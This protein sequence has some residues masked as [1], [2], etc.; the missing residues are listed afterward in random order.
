VIRAALEKTDGDP[1]A[2]KAL[3]ADLGIDVEFEVRPAGAGK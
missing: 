1:A 2:A 3:L